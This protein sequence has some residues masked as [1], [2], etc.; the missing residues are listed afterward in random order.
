MK[1]TISGSPEFRF[2]ATN[3][4]GHAITIGASKSI[5]GDESGFRPMQLVLAA[6][7]SCAGIDAVNILKKSRVPFTELGIEVEGKRLEGATPSPFTE[8]HVKFIV[9]GGREED[10]AKAEKASSL[11]VEKYCSVAASLDKSIKV[12]HSTEIVP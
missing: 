8:I 4:Q 10:R 1:V 5:G 9:R 6:A 7:G 12:T 11:S 3:D 2:Q